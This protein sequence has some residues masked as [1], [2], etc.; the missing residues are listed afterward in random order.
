MEYGASATLTTPGGTLTFNAATGDT[1][2]LDPSQ[3][4]GL[5]QAPL[6][7]PIDKK[8][9]APGGIV[10]PFLRDAR[11]VTLGGE[12][13]IRSSGTETGYVTA[14]NALEQT[15]RAALESIEDADGTFAITPT[16]LSTM[17][18]TVRCDVPV[19][20]AGLLVKTFLF[21]LVAADPDFA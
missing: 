14:R 18:L 7:T 1:L 19:T 12:L 6:R 20:F 16:G 13:F 3:S 21:G 9:G 5:D 15:I 2:W 8:P 11:H 17:S 10:F 4:S